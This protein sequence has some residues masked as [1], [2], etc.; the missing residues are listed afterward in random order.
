MP[1]KIVNPNVDIWYIDGSGISNCFGAGVYG[2]RVNHR[3]G[4]PMG[5]LSTV[6]QVEVMAILMCTELLLCKNN[7]GEYIPAVI[8]GQQ[9]QHLKPCTESAPVWESMQAL[10]TQSGYNK[11]ALLWTPGPHGIPGN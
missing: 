5:S 9:W 7:E 4:I 2:P 6:F 8:A 1:G 3:E 10:E 11:V